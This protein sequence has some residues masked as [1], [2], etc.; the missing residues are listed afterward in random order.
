M[1]T[2]LTI[3]N[4][5]KWLKWLES[6][7]GEKAD[8]MKSRILR[9]LGLKGLA[10]T[11]D[12]T[13]RRSGRLQNSMNFGDQDN[14]FTLKVGK[15]SYVVFGTAVD[16]AEAVETGITPEGAAKNKGRFVPGFWK[17]GVFHY[18]PKYK[19]ANGKSAGMVLT[20]KVVPGAHMFQ[21][22]VDRMA[23]DVNVVVEFEF[24]R[25]YAELFT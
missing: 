21:K 24:K 9:T 25:L 13:P 10:Y 20:G 12:G 7:P 3:K 18:I 14:V 11:K 17:S 4:L 1:K 2:E 5:D 16:Y 6:V 22:G 19:D 15:T 23:E 8:Q